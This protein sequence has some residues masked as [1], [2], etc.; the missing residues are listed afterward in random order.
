MKVKKTK[1][2]LLIFFGIEKKIR[3]KKGHLGLLKFF[4]TAR[5][6]SQ[7]YLCYLPLPFFAL[8]HK[9][10]ELEHFLSYLKAMFLGF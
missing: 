6:F 5:I 2:M 4:H 9:Y 10:K 8:L 1:V 7:A 3:P